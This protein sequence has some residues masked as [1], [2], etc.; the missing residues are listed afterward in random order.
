MDE[1]VEFAKNVEQICIAKSNV[2]ESLA[3]GINLGQFPRDE[4]LM[5]TSNIKTI[6][7]STE[8]I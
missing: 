7:Q 6:H 2:S 4:N 8:T 3:N 5:V 1:V